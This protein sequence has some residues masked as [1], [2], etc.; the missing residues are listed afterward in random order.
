M[1]FRDWFSLEPLKKR[2]IKVVWNKKLKS[3]TERAQFT[4]SSHTLSC[5]THSTRIQKISTLFALS[6]FQAASLS[7]SHGLITNYTCAYLNNHFCC[8]VP[9]KHPGNAWTQYALRTLASVQRHYGDKQDETMSPRLP[10][11]D[12]R[13]KLHTP[14]VWRQSRCRELGSKPSRHCI[15]HKQ[16]LIHIC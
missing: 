8:S 3:L 5:L 4:L 7:L 2:S 9:R 16:E 12:R 6:S 15:T 10:P 14:L 1:G 11:H 13:S